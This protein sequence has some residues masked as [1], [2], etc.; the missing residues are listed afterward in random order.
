MI[1]YQRQEEILQILDKHHSMSI[2]KLAKVLYTSEATVR[3]DLNALERMGL[4]HRIY[5]GVVLAKYA[6]SDMPLFVRKQENAEEKELIAA[7]AAELVPEGST[8]ILDASSTTQHMVRFLAAYKSLTVITNGL[9]IAEGFTDSA[10]KVLCTGGRYLPE[11]AS[12]VGYQ[13]IEMLQGI[14]ADFLF[15]SSQGLSEEGE[16]TDNSEEETAVRRTMLQRAKTKVFLCDGSKLGRKSLY[17]VCV[18][19]ELQ[20]IICDQPLPEKISEHIR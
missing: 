7:R 16:V 19:E 5:G 3:R 10:V 12:F 14:C 9:K 11:N 1:Q 13:A 2:K 20:Q 15:F 8:V 6:S 4:V 18:A 17:R